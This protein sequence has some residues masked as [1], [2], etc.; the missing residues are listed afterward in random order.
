MNRM[1]GQELIEW[2][3]THNAESMDIEIQ[4]RDGGGCYTGTDTLRKDEIL[5]ENNTVII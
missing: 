2:I 1:T 3:Q 4:Y 5:I